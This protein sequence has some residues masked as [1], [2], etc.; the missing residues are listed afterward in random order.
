[1]DILLS[2][3]LLVIALLVIV[4]SLLFWF[5]ISKRDALS[6]KEVLD[7]NAEKFGVGIKTDAFGLLILMGFAMLSMS[8]FL[9]YQDY[10]EQ[11]SNTQIQVQQW[12]AKVRELEKSLNTKDALV[13]KVTARLEQTI[14]DV[15]S[16][17]KTYRLRLNLV[18]AVDSQAN[19]FT[20]KVKTLVRRSNESDNEQLYLDADFE[21]GPGGLVVKFS[22]L[23]EG[24]RISVI[25]EDRGKTWRSHDMTVP[26]AYLNMVERSL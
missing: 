20:A 7:I 18:F 6:G 19:P 22:D 12:T 9:L 8:L 26:S 4:G 13:D 10:E 2:Q 16:S 24:D 17:L 21:R 25:V 1:V 14:E 23:R 3:S 15:T 11:V 5:A